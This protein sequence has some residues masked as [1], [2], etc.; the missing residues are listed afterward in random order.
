MKLYAFLLV[1]F[2]FVSIGS[3][4]A[5]DASA[6]APAAIVQNFCAAQHQMPSG[7]GASMEMDIQASLPGLK[8]VGRFHALRKINPIGGI[9][10]LKASFEGDNTV[11]NQVVERYLQ[12]EAEAQ[13]DSP[14]ALAVN[15]TNYKFQYKGTNEVDGR[16]VHV[17]QVTPKHKLKGLFK[18]DVWI[19]AATYL[20]VRE[21]GKLIKNPSIFVRKIAFVRTFQIRDGVSVPVQ[22]QSTVNTLF[23]S[24][25]LTVDYSNFAF[26][27]EDDAS[28]TQ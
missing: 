16:Q 15:T 1:V 3:A 26:G 28:N 18:G 14:D 13:K 23:G 11:K 19:D 4:L 24:A 17:F 21:S 22:V 8:K 7:K 6:L 27:D 2:S 10:Y 5:A 9:S 20:P 25:E 12:A